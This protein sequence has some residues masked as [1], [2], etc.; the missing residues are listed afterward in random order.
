[1]KRFVFALFVP[2]LL[3]AMTATAS[4]KE[5][6]KDFQ[7][8][9]DVKEGVT[10]HLEHGDGDVTISPWDNDIVDVEVH[11]RAESKSLGVGG[12]VYFDVEFKQSAHPVM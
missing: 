10:L 5:I 11:Y 9:F 8:S 4:G 7:K 2:S 1:M 6:K 3:V 12:K